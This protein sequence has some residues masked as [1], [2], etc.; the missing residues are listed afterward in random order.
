MKKQIELGHMDIESCY[1]LGVR[2]KEQ[3]NLVEAERC[4]REIVEY[5]PHLPDPQ[6]SLGVV[7]QLQERLP[8]A[9]EH[10][11]TAVALD[12]CFVKSHYNLATALWQIGQYDEAIDW[13]RKTLVLDHTHAEAH[14]N[15]GM[16][17]MLTGNMAEG[18]KEYEWRWQVPGCAIP[19]R[20]F[21]KPTWNGSP[22]AGRVLFIHS[23]QGLGDILQFIRYVP[24]AGSLGGKVI[25]S[26]PHS[27][28]ALF[29]EIEGVVAVVGT[30]G[31]F[32]EFD[33]QIPILSLPFA[34]GTT[35]DTI[36]AQI[37][38]LRPDPMKAAAWQCLLTGDKYFRIGLVWQ[39]SNKHHNDSNRSIPLALLASLWEVPGVSLYT[40]QLGEG[41][42]QVASLSPGLR[43]IDLTDR[44]ADFSDTAA[45]VV[46]L[47]LIITV[48]TAVAHLSGAL[49]RRVWV[50][51]PYKADWRW[52]YKGEWT[53][54][55]PTMRLFRQTTAGDWRGVID[56]IREELSRLPCSA[57]AHNQ[58]G[59]ELLRSGLAEEAGEAFNAAIA[60]NPTDAEAY[61]NLGVTFDSQ[62]KYLEA[63]GV[64]ETAL[65]IRPDFPHALF[66]KGNTHR[67]LGEINAARLSYEKALVSF[68]GLVQAELCLA[69]IWKEEE[70]FIQAR[71]CLERALA[72][73][74]GNAD[75]LQSLG[76][77]YQSEE[78]FPEAIAAYQQALTV[79]PDNLKA[80]NM[81]GSVFHL[82]GKYAAAEEYYSKALALKPD[83]LSVLNNLGALYQ[84]QGQFVESIVVL[85]R[86]IAVDPCYADGHWNLALSLLACG[87]LKE[88]WQEYEWRFKKSSPVSERHFQ[89]PRWDGSPLRGKA[90]LLHCEQ[91]FGDTIQFVRYVPLVIERG[92][93]VIIECQVPALERLLRSLN[94]VAEVVV[95]GDPLPKFDCHFPLM[96][97]PLLFGTTIETIPSQ[98]SYLAA[99]TA[100]V[101]EWRHRLGRTNKFRVGLVWYAKQSQVLNRKR[102]CPL[103]MF[104]PLWDVPGIEFYTLQIGVGTEQLEAFADK[105]KIIDCTRDIKDFADTAA[106]IAN[107]DLVISIDTAIAHL[108]GALGARTWVVLPYVAE[109]RWLC[110]REDNPWYPGMRLFRQSRADDWQGVMMSVTSSLHRYSRTS[111]T[112]ST[113]DSFIG[114]G[115]TKRADETTYAETVRRPLLQDWRSSG[116]KI[117]LAWAGRKSHPLD[118][119]RSCP[120]AALA[121]L[122]AFKNMHF[123][124]LQ[125][126]D[127]TGQKAELL[128]GMLLQDLVGHIHDFEDT[129]SLIAN[130]DLVITID[131]AVAHLAGA[132]GKPTWLLLPYAAD[133]RWM[134]NRKDTPWYPTMKLF[135]QPEPG[136]WG[137]VIQAVAASLAELTIR[138]TDGFRQQLQYSASSF[139]TLERVYMEKQLEEYLRE[140]TINATNPEA[141]LNSGAALAMLGR[142]REAIPYYQRALELSPEYVQAHLNLGFSLLSLGEFAAGWSHNEWRH[143]MLE[144]LLPDWPLLGGH[145]LGGIRRA[146]RFLYT[147]NRDMEILFSLFALS[148]SWRKWATV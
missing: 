52:G 112:G 59:I 82:I 85:R 42:T 63:L 128:P 28:H 41:A 12:P 54:W 64:Y 117:G 23:E 96:S 27:L 108:A 19:K 36:P 66:N 15:L 53:P 7:L 137:S 56:Q 17:L 8:E 75:V 55:Y 5:A 114:A 61:S 100:D 34:F 104:A 83:T 79:A 74:P 38:Y 62:K 37:P 26:V 40:L 10:Y 91:G 18:L 47:D 6:H 84:S 90:I 136:D 145:D 97:L 22:L 9:I 102:S 144:S 95:A 45:L 46:N 110:G 143:K 69:Q 13:L 93:M 72:Y 73:E 141:H 65:K 125:P 89:Q 99:E 130:L 111:S 127:E 119:L 131:T 11:R 30:D 51:L 2:L 123:Y 121:P 142:H 29:A 124:S 4:F 113:E 25:V 103:R 122:A 57:A 16:L 32:P 118:H 3:G 67:H 21:G 80:L 140:S 60:L 77:A 107:L 129:A 78:K 101:E 39:G 120:V 98:V 44:I 81:L 50:A 35:A 116:N 86:A 133:W 58:R 109:W 126:R 132:M 138:D 76:E 139:N 14:L 92:G 1:Q 105:Y 87:E 148:R 88:G 33:V 147:V 146:H 94:I 70:N 68:P 20:D 49:G 43:L 134:T 135:R 71:S 24:L 106:F 48:D 31:P 115:L